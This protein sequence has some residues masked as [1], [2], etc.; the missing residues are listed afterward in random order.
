M[1]F[2]L[3]N[4]P[5]KV[6]MKVTILLYNSFINP[7]IRS[8]PCT[9]TLVLLELQ[10]WDYASLEEN[11]VRAVMNGVQELCQKEK[12]WGALFSCEIHKA[13]G[14]ASVLCQAVSDW[15]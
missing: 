13:I 4:T 2:C 11:I 1:E 14:R 3:R 15:F 10:N 5:D 6:A 9:G 8:R 7:G 12:F